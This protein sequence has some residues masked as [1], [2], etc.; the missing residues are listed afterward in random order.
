MLKLWDGQAPKVHP[1][2]SPLAHLF[3]FFCFLFTST[4]TFSRARGQWLSSSH[5]LFLPFLFLM[6]GAAYFRSLWIGSNAPRPATTQ[7]RFFTGAKHF[8]KRPPG[9]TG[10]AAS[11][12][13]VPPPPPSNILPA[14]G[15]SLPLLSAARALAPG[16]S[17][18]R[19][20][21]AGARRLWPRPSK[22]S[23]AAPAGRLDADDNS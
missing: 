21:V 12:Q 6:G 2:H 20:F 14:A 8:W 13:D 16:L 22:A 5:L 15:L 18:A 3:Y 7:T 19:R 17:G 9:P 23:E 4:F 11:H 10:C 1:G